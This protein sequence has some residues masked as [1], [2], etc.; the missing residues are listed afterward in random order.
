MAL[1][2]KQNYNGIQTH[3][4]R[5]KLHGALQPWGKA[6]H[7]AGVRRIRKGPQRRGFLL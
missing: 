2:L 7:P 3:Y 6:P 1:K 5:D 4:P